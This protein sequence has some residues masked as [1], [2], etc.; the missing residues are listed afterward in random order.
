[1]PAFPET[2]CREN[3]KPENRIVPRFFSGWSFKSWSST[4]GRF[5]SGQTSN[6]TDAYPANASHD[7]SD[8]VDKRLNPISFPSRESSSHEKADI[9]TPQ[10]VPITGVN[11]KQTAVNPPIIG[12]GPDTI[13]TTVDISTEVSSSEPFNSGWPAPLDIV[14]VLDNVYAPSPLIKTAGLIF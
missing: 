1:M 2:D 5:S 3:T 10:T 12:T 4:M 9:L 11:M 14:I 13:W 8:V 7:T 6:S